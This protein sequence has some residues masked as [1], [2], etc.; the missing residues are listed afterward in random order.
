MLAASWSTEHTQAKTSAHLC[1]HTHTYTHANASTHPCTHTHANAPMRMHARTHTWWHSSPCAC[2]Q[3]SCASCSCCRAT[4]GTH[5][6]WWWT[7][8]M[9]LAV[10]S[11]ATC[12]I[13]SRSAVPPAATTRGLRSTCVRRATQP[14]HTGGCGAVGYAERLHTMSYT[15]PTRVCC[16]VCCGCLRR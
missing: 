9:C 13:A 8:S 14:P 5:G 7:R 2:L 6:R 16:A 11:A 1:A 4:P 3:A 12:C 15:I 10:A